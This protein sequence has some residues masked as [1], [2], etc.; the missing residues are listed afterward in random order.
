M[1]KL[2]VQARGGDSKV[3]PGFKALTASDVPPS[4]PVQADPAARFWLGEVRCP[5]CGYVNDESE[6]TYFGRDSARCADCA[7][8][9]TATEWAAQ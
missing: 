4:R 8:E 3:L 9:F 6:L 2:E 5:L 7:G 1:R